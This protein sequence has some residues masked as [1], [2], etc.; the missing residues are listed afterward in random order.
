MEVWFQYGLNFRF[1]IMDVYLCDLIFEID[2]SSF[3]WTLIGVF[4][5]IIFP[6]YHLDLHVTFLW[7]KAGSHLGHSVRKKIATGTNI[8]IGTM[9]GYMDF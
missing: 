2:F 7:K 4:W 3:F 1:F 8:G 9:I 6:K 5:L